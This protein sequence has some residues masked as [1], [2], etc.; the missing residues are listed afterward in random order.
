MSEARSRRWRPILVAA[1]A[2]IV[3]A[4]TGTTL[5]DLGPW[6]QSLRE[7]AWKPPDAAFGAIWTTIF[8]LAAIS[9]V[10]AWRNAKTLSGRQWIVG[11]FA[12]NGFLNVVW[13]LIFFKL[14]RP[15][16]ALAE[17]GLLW[18]SILALIVALFRKSVWA[19]VLLLPYLAWVSTAA[20]LNY[21]VVVLNGP[22]Q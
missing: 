20:L 21:D 11:L 13:S 19:S 4:A 12:V 3:V 15:D 7:P 16:L 18:I 17:V 2:A 22:F 14:Q 9:G 8:A 6:Y 5:T 1:L 10:L